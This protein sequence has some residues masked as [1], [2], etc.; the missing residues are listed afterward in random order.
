MFAWHDYCFGDEAAG[1]ASHTRNFA[2]AAAHVKQ[3]DEGTMMTE[4]GATTSTKDLDQMVT[5]ADQNMVPWLEWAFCGCGDPTGAI[6]TSSEALVVDPV[7][8]P[9]AANLVHPT[10]NALVEPYPQVIAGTPRS[11]GFDRATR[12]FSFRYSTGAATG[13]RWFPAGSVTEIA[14]PSLDYPAG[15]AAHVRG[16][17]IDSAARAGILR[18]SSCPG[19]RTVTV[20]LT[21]GKRTSASCRAGLDIDIRRTTVRPGPRTAERAIV[22]RP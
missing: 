10:L 21:A 4:F 2:Y 13:R 7:E 8:P 20:S 9:T 1:C 5:L 3:T 17:A 19:A 11:W 15:Y 6:P 14:T 22:G 12:T 16:A 18:V